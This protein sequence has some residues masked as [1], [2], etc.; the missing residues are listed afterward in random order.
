MLVS[1]PKGTGTL[2]SGI[3]SLWSTGVSGMLGQTSSTSTS[4]GTGT[5]YTPPQPTSVNA[6]IPQPYVVSA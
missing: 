4:K 2:F 6:A 1:S 5:S 3:E